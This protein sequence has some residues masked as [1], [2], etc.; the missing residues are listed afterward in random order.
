[1]NKKSEMQTQNMMQTWLQLLNM[2]NN[3]N[4]YNLILL[5]NVFADDLWSSSTILISKHDF[6]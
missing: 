6:R 1:M 3:T 2:L 5:T 4:I